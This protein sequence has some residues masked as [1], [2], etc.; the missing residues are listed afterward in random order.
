MH[1]PLA[2]FSLS[3]SPQLAGLS[4]IELR[5]KVRELQK[6]FRPG[7]AHEVASALALR[8]TQPDDALAVYL[9]MSHHGHV[10]KVLRDEL[11]RYPS[12]DK[13]TETV[14]GVANGDTLEA[15]GQTITLSTDCRKMGRD[16]NGNESYTRGIL[17]LLAEHGPFRL[18]Y[19][20]TLLRAADCRASQN[21]HQPGSQ[22]DVQ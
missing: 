20:E 15:N 21:T 10:R 13:D 9:V 17:R 1:L 16:A 22:G 7:V 3:D 8:Q 11:P 12:D 6:A 2:K 19:L 4:G 14:R 5:K 18:V